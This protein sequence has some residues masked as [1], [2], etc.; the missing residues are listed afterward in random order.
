MKYLVW[1]LVL[2]LVVLHQ[3]IWNWD[4]DH[5]LLGC[6]PVTLAYH[7]GISIAAS[8]VWF[9]ASTLAWPKDL[10]DDSGTAT[11]SEEGIV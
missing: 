2:L 11:E 9:L 6:I 4:N 5:L 7:A 8:I 1:G 10:E 3:D